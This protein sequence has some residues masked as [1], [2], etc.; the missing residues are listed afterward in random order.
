[1][2]Q[3]VLVRPDGMV[4]L[5][6]PAMCGRRSHIGGRHRVGDQK[7]QGRLRSPEVFVEVVDPVSAKVYVG[8]E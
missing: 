4:T 3:E 2:T 1:M 6:R 5:R 7:A 8:G